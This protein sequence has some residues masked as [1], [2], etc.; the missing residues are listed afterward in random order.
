MATPSSPNPSGPAIKP[1]DSETATD[2]LERAYARHTANVAT[3]WLQSD[4]EFVAKSA[5]NA[6][7]AAEGVAI[8][9]ELTPSHE[10]KIPKRQ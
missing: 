8:V 7:V 3:P 1:A 4:V 10:T 6:V 2:S 5:D 9:D